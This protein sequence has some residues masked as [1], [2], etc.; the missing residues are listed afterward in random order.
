MGNVA[1]RRPLAVCPFV[2]RDED[3]TEHRLAWNDVIQCD[4]AASSAFSWPGYVNDDVCGKKEGMRR[5]PVFIDI[6]RW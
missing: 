5:C 2:P 3:W 6:E 1:V 4:G